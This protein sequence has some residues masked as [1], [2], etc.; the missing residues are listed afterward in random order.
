[1]T[2]CTVKKQV[3]RLTLEEMTEWRDRAYCLWQANV[4]DAK[5][6]QGSPFYVVATEGRRA[7]EQAAERWRDIYLSYQAEL[8]CSE[9]PPPK[10]FRRK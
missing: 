8:L 5:Q 3:S 7:A 10:I 1:M 6:K 9:V 4:F 2:S